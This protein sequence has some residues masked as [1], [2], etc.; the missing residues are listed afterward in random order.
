MS[1]T[2]TTSKGS[3]LPLMQLKG[4]DY[5]QVAHRLVWLVDDESSYTTDLEFLSLKE[6][7]CV[8]KMTLTIL[9]KDGNVVKRVQDCKMET[10][11]DFPD[12]VEKAITGAL[13]RC[14]AQ[15]GKGTNYAIQDLDEGQRL[16]DSPLD[17]PTK[18]ET[19]ASPVVASHSPSAPIDTKSEVPVKSG[20]RKPAEKKNTET[21]KGEADSWN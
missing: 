20:F 9:G 12:F 7:S 11:K 17:S 6:D 3:V 2:Y 5:M 14:L 10:K 15:V 4:K 21:P 1:K 16:A 18:A 19:P 13:G 8:A